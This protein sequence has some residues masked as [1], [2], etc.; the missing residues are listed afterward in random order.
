MSVPSEMNCCSKSGIH[1]HSP[2]SQIHIQIVHRI[3]RLFSIDFPEH[4]EG[5]FHFMGCVRRHVE[6]VVPCRF[7][8][9][10]TFPVNRRTGSV[11]KGVEPKLNYFG[12]QVLLCSTRSQPQDCRSL[13]NLL[14]LSAT[15]FPAA[16]PSTR[17]G[18]HPWV[19]LETSTLHRMRLVQHSSCSRVSTMLSASPYF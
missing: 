9:F 14:L 18:T 7:C 6:I 1:E 17:Q 10:L 3:A 4:G 13:L 16:L 11:C 12:Q 2:N 8:I 5:G 19:A 15:R